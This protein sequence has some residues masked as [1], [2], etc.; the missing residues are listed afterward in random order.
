MKTRRS[1]T[2]Y[3]FDPSIS[4]TNKYQR[5]LKR[6]LKE[7]T[8]DLKLPDDKDSEPKFSNNSDQSK[9]TTITTPSKKKSPYNESNKNDSKD[10]L[11]IAIGESLSCTVPSCHEVEKASTTTLS[12]SSPSPRTPSTSPLQLARRRV[13]K[14]PTNINQSRKRTLKERQKPIHDLINN[15]TTRAKRSNTRSSSSRVPRNTVLIGTDPYYRSLYQRELKKAMKQSITTF[16]KESENQQMEKDN[17]DGVDESAASCSDDD[18]IDNS[19]PD[20]E[21]SSVSSST[22]I[23]ESA[24]ALPPVASVPCILG[25][26][27]TSCAATTSL[28]STSLGCNDTSSLSSSTCILGSVETPS[29]T[30]LSSFIC[31]NGGSGP[32]RQLMRGRSRKIP[33]IRPPFVNSKKNRGVVTTTIP[34]NI[35]ANFDFL[36]LWRKAEKKLGITLEEFENNNSVRCSNNCRDRTSSLS[37]NQT[38]AMYGRT[39]FSGMEVR[40][41]SLIQLLVLCKKNQY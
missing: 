16:E 33:L 21:T 39:L 13:T 2:G 18:G 32:R 15:T 27:E 4:L 22:Y 11:S 3:T 36:E 19:F 30:M 1:R 24:D 5:D 14:G 9:V 31:S 40:Q 23:S 7:S 8:Y 25:N 34:S 29:S 37:T 10:I 26:V 41:I 38:R 17:D 20:I 28:S 35:L 12:S 6:A